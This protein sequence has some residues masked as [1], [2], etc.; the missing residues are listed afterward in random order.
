MSDIHQKNIES[1]SISLASSSDI[2]SWSYGEVKTSETINYKTLAPEPDG[3][4]C[5]KIFG[6]VKNYECACGKYKKPK[7]KGIICEKCGVEVTESIVR[8]QRFG[9]IKLC[10]P[11][12]HIWMFKYTPSKLSLI[13]NLKVKEIEEI[14]YFISYVVIEQGN[15]TLKE[16]TIIDQNNCHKYFLQEL[17]DIKEKK[18]LSGKELI[19]CEQFIHVFSN[20]GNKKQFIPFFDICEFITLQ[21]KAKFGIG[22]QAIQELLQ[23]INFK[24]ELEELEQKKNSYHQ[25]IIRYSKRFQLLQKIVENNSLI[26][27][28]TID[29][30]PIIPPEMRPII[31]L[32]NGRF[33]SSDVNE[34]YRRIIIRN[35]RLKRAIELDSP[36]IM[37]NN[38]KRMLQEAVDALFDNTKKHKPFLGK[39]KHVLKSLTD[40]LKGKQGRFRQNLLG[41][42]VDYSA[43]SV[44]VVGPDLKLYQ[45]GIPKE[46]ILKIYLPHIIGELLKKQLAKNIKS[47]QKLIEE[48]NKIIWPI[49][50]ELANSRPLLLNRAPTLHR[51]G[52]QAFQPKIINSKAIT[53]HPLVTTAFNADFDGDQMA[54]HLP[55][56]D[57]AIAEARTLMIGSN[58]ILGL[59][60]GKPITIPNLDM[61]LGIYYLTSEKK[62]E[63]DQ[64]I[65]F[66][67][68]EKDVLFAHK[69][70]IICENQLILLSLE[71]IKNKI[72]DKNFNLNSG[73]LITTPGKIIFNSIL[74][75]DF[76]YVN[77]FSD[78][79]NFSKNDLVF[80]NKESDYLSVNSKEDILKI[81]L[82]RKIEAGFNKSNVS[83]L[84]STIYDQY[85]NQIA[86]ILDDLKDLG[87]EYATKSSTTFSISDLI[88]KEKDKNIVLEYKNKLVEETSLKVKKYWNFYLKGFLT[89]KERHQHVVNSWSEA[90]DKIQDFLKNLIEDEKN[91]SNPLIM[92]LKSGARGN[93]SN[94]TQLSGIRGLMNNPK[95]EIIEIPIFSSFYEGL[96]ISEFFISTHGARKGLA[97]VALKT[98]DSGYLTRR[99]VDVAQDVIVNDDDCGTLEY[100]EV[101]DIIDEKTNSLIVPLHD[102]ILGRYVLE[103]LYDKNNRIIIQKNQLIDRK[104][105]KEIIDNG[106]Q[107]V[108]IRS[109]LKCKSPYGVC[110]KCYGWHLAN[111]KE[112]EIGES[113]GIISAQ[114]IGE[115]GT[116]LTMRTFHTGGVAGE[117]DI[118]QG[119]PRI[120]ELFDVTKPKG[121]VATISP[122]DGLIT[123]IAQVNDYQLKITIETEYLSSN[124][125]YKKYH[126]SETV[127]INDSLR[128]KVG[129]YVT[130]GQKLTNGNLDLKK[131]LATTDIDE[132]QKY[133]IKEVQWVYR[134]QGIEISDKYIEII[135]SQMMNKIL[136]IGSG[137]SDYQV[138]TLIHKDKF[139][140]ENKKLF[141]EKKNPIFGKIV[142]LSVKKAPLLANSFLSSASFQ[143]TSRVLSNAAAIGSIDHLYGLKTNVLIGNLIP[144]GTG[145]KN[146]DEVIAESKKAIYNYY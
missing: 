101:S 89:E 116:Q 138:G 91:Q 44:I 38:E 119:L 112:V 12:C 86:K 8:R 67:A 36:V 140:K 137:D 39:D 104:I 15:S 1:I 77:N 93:I 59:K 27:Q 71:A 4:F 127:F 69:N 30:I 2:I 88:F 24:K 114:S 121:A 84:I 11:V 103:D 6:P 50:E 60:D 99:L 9:H 34:L 42:R 92:M 129:D 35:E 33:T 81:L 126:I 47:A 29:I 22:A 52:I 48:Q 135:V 53:L 134:L 13:L 40:L 100:I 102:R 19:K 16:R 65:H 72:S 82:E 57:A 45:C 25:N 58:N 17:L 78:L 14:I 105:A 46:I 141:L 18:S 26:N 32:D 125:K 56:G 117:Y 108:K 68:N 110:R 3:L 85:T 41:K 111:N 80:L 54:V 37:L 31:Q 43:R 146:E 115:P 133:I 131:L 5:E 61:I 96:N 28:L 97:D 139:I 130:V 145:L 107:K 118:T 51:L 20:E 124:K 94:F 113:V 73:Y 63:K 76:F 62:F 55:L 21:S 74:P 132:V 10:I 83:S 136:I 23:K 143:D 128:V 123:N 75:K 120:K 87:F 7:N 122:V 144:A 64:K 106:I 70:E 95:G 109:V 79:K 49:V 142:L 98:A 90:R 66:F